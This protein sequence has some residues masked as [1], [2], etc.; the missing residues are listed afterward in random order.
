MQPWSRTTETAVIWRI[1][2]QQIGVLM[3]ELLQ[4]LIDYGN[5]PAPTFIGDARAIGFRLSEDLGTSDIWQYVGI[6]YFRKLPAGMAALHP[7]HF[8]GLGQTWPVPNHSSELDTAGFVRIA[9]HVGKHPVV[10]GLLEFCALSTQFELNKVLRSETYDVSAQKGALGGV[11][12]HFDSGP[13]R[14]VAQLFKTNSLRTSVM[15]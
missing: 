9:L 15:L 4:Q 13:S 11:E 5:Q 6:G 7:Y 3:I 14:R 2:G 12:L 10:E 8:E 1:P